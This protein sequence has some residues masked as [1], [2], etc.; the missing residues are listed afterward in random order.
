[1][2]CIEGGKLRAIDSKAF[3]QHLHG[4]FDQPRPRKREPA[5]SHQHHQRAGQ[6]A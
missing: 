2:R 5:D 6:F 4:R 3:T 1:M